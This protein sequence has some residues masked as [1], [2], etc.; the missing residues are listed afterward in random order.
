MTGKVELPKNK[1]FRKVAVLLLILLL[2]SV[3]YL[4]LN[5]GNHHF[6][7]LPFVGP[8]KTITQNG[9]TDT[10]Y[11]SIPPF[12][13]QD[14][15]GNAFTKV[16]MLGDIY[17]ANFF[18]TR[19]PTICPKMSAHLLDLQKKFSKQQG[20][21]ILSHTVDPEFDTPEVLRKYANKVHADSVKWTFVTGR[22]EDIYNL[23]FDGYFA[24]VSKH[25][26]A[27][28]GFLHSELIFIVDRQGRL[29]GSYD[30]HGNVIPGFDGTS[31]SEMKKLSDAI[32]NLLLEEFVPKKD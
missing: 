4:I 17:I 27:P 28:G 29:R 12:R 19:C 10:V 23:A 11:H 20:V 30:D 25:E 14:Q 15:S 24:T 26:A 8:R 31:T 6:Q 2:P 21:K 7:K 5:R 22:K 32:D 16:D 13:L 9:A 1:R 3:F 18:F